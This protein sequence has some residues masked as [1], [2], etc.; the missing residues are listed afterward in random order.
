MLT[1]TPNGEMCLFCPLGF[2]VRQR[3]AASSF[4]LPMHFSPA[5]RHR[6]PRGA[7][8]NGQLY[9][10][11]LREKLSNSKSWIFSTKSQFLFSFE[12]S[13]KYFHEKNCQILKVIFSRQITTFILIL[14]NKRIFTR[15]IVK[16]QAIFKGEFGGFYDS[17]LKGKPIVLRSK[18]KGREECG[19][20]GF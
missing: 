15:K 3:C 5:T 8:A 1:S 7:Y 9:T 4:L 17:V 10:V 6:S 19:D 13:L 20:E 2:F 11:F 12:N 14:S 18:K 16:F